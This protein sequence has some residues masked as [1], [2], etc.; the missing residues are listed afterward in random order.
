MTLRTPRN[1]HKFSPAKNQILP[2]APGVL[3]RAL[4]FSR[5]APLTLSELVTVALHALSGI[6]ADCPGIPLEARRILLDL[7]DLLGEE[8]LPSLAAATSHTRS[9][10]EYLAAARAWFRD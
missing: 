4:S 5:E 7:L 9:D 6:P 3:F 1:H 10:A 8:S 2:Q